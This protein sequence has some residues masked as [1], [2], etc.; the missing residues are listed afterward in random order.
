MD[1]ESTDQIARIGK[2]LGV[3]ARV[4]ILQLLKEQVL[5]VGAIAARLDI[6]QGAVSQHLRILREAGLVQ[7]EKRGYYVHYAIDPKA[8]QQWK[9]VLGDL[10][11]TDRPP[12]NGGGTCAGMKEAAASRA[13]R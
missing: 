7:S 13:K 11:S 5:C 4:R 2:V 3:E 10:L 9:E 12:S 8:F 1:V 6:T